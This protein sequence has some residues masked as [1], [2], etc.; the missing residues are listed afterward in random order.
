MLSHLQIQNFVLIDQLEL[1]FTNGL[2]IIT[3][4]TGAGKSIV[5]DALAL[6]LGERADLSVIGQYQNKCDLSAIFNISKQPAVIAW[7]REHDYAD[8]SEEDCIVR[9]VMYKDGKSR[10]TINGSPC[11]LQQLK[12]F[13]L[14]LI[15]IHSQ[16]QHQLLLKATHQRQL[17]D[18]FGN[19]PSVCQNVKEHFQ[20]WLQIKNKL[21]QLVDRQQNLH[22][23]KDLILFQINELEKV[24]LIEGEYEQLDQEHKRLANVE[25]LIQHCQMALELLCDGET[26]AQS[27]LYKGQQKLDSIKG[28]ERLSS[29][30]GLLTNAAIQLNEAVSEIRGFWDQLEINPERLQHVEARLSTLHSLARKYQVSPHELTQVYIQLST[31][32]AELQGINEQLLTLQTEYDTAWQSYLSAAKQLHEKRQ[33]A[34]LKLSKKVNS[35]IQKLGMPSGQFSISLSWSE[36]TASVNGCDSI[37]FLISS[38]PGQ[39]SQPLRKVASGGEMSRIA[40]AIYVATAES[41]TTPIL[42][43]DEIDVGIGGSTAAVVGELLKKLGKTAQIICITHLPQVAAFGDQHFC[44]RKEISKKKSETSIALLTEEEKIYEI[45]R[46]LGGITITER[47]LEHA[48]E[49]IGV[50]C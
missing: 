19:H 7:L 2:S 22:I 27:L 38:N 25:Q 28:H 49:L 33:G 6:L 9:R 10:Q 29:A 1:S 14:L 24:Q 15:N 31:Q 39:P 18:F 41:N 36:E 46:M 40:L 23:Q 30:S 48:K 5:I 13:S 45:A 8:D 3:G 37:E 12:E 11:T 44:V 43:F 34:A 47:T 21:A 26:N 4:E 16:N 20:Q 17:L 32:L 35:S 50:T 42:V